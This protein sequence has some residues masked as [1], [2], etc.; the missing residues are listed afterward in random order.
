MGATTSPE[1]MEVAVSAANFSIVVFF[2]NCY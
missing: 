2:C 1:G